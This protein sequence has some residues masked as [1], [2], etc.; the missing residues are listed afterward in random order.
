MQQSIVYLIVAYA[1]WVVGKRYAP[2]SL[3]RRLNAWLHAK[4][5]DFGWSRMAE[6]FVPAASASASC[7]DGCSSCNS[8]ATNEEVATTKEFSVTP[9]A[10]RKTIRR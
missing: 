4:C 3:R 9:D 1:A 8:C 6:K 10:L 5:T 7:G 2:V